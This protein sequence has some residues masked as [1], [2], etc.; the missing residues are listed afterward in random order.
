MV[1]CEAFALRF[2][3][4]DMMP[5]PNRNGATVAMKIGLAEGVVYRRD[6]LAA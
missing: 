4:N 5:D 2:D 1:P 3:R 6:A